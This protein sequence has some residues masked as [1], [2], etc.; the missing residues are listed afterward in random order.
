MADCF[1][2]IIDHAEE[3]YG[4]RVNY[5]TTDCDG[6]SKK[7]CQILGKWCTWL[8]VPEWWAHQV[9]SPQFRFCVLTTKCFSNSSNSLLE[10]VSKTIIWH[11]TLL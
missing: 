3:K 11:K 9:N 1:M 7:G 2:K 10:I 6:G 5:F 4:C 8:L